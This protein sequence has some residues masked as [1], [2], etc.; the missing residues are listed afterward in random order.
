ME[1]AKVETNTKEAR[2]DDLTDSLMEG[3][4]A[5]YTSTQADID[6]MDKLLDE[7]ESKLEE[8][9]DETVVEVEKP[10]EADDDDPYT[11]LEEIEEKYKAEKEK[12]AVLQGTVNM[13]NETK[14]KLKV[15]LDR[16]AKIMKKHSEDLEKVKAM[17]G[18]IEAAK[19]KK[20]LKE[21]KLRN[22]DL[23]K[24][25]ENLM[26]EKAKAEAEVARVIKHNDFL[27]EAMEKTKKDEDKQP[28]K[29]DIKC[30]D[31]EDR[32]VCGYRGGDCKFLHPKKKCEEFS[33]SGSCSRRKCVELH[34]DNNCVFW[35]EG[36][37]RYSKEECKRGEHNI[38]TFNT[39]P[40]RKTH[41]DTKRD[42]VVEL[43]KLQQM[44]QQQ[45]MFPQP[46]MQQFQLQKYEAQQQ[47]LQPQQQLQGQAQLQ[48]LQQLQGQAQRQP[49]QQLQG[50]VQLQHLQ[51]LQSQAQ[52]Q[53]QQQLQG[54]YQQQ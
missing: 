25:V 13:L 35:R 2:I 10:N 27:E 19:A 34:K 9:K 39:K 6:N 23:I 38:E 50:R 26:V 52:V 36:H 43:M 24:Q 18:G 4:G 8:D 17:K 14:D 32:G 21:T 11:R 1:S 7:Y 47:Q 40:K 16:Q 31:F 12:N 45:M 28:K 42:P 22:A 41:E 54:V 20:E 5:E 53:P 44:G 3:F 48:P 30:R 49:Q 15:Q 46:M 37:C 51:Q 29:M 33:R